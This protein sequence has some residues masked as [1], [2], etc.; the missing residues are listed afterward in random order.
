MSEEEELRQKLARK[1]QEL[2]IVQTIA[3]EINAALE[4]DQIFDVV[5]ASMDN[6]LGFRHAMILVPDKTGGWLRVAASRGYAEKGIGATVEFGKGQIGVVARRRRVM[7]MVGMGTQM[8]IVAAARRESQQAGHAIANET[9]LPGLP[10]VRSQVVIPL[11]AKDRLIGVYVVESPEHNAFDVLD[12]AFVGIV[13]SQVATAIDNASA[14]AEL[15]RQVA[16][17]SK[18]LADALSKLS[19]QP[20]PLS[21]AR[22]VDGRYR[23]IRKLGA[24]GMGTVYEVERIT[25]Q[26]RFA[27]KTLRGRTEPD[28]MARFAREAHVAAEQL[29]PNLVPVVDIGIADGALFLVMPLVDG[30]S[31]EQQRSRFGDATWARPLLGHVAI[32]LAALHERGI[33]HRDLKPANILLDRGVP[34]IADFGLAALRGVVAADTAASGELDAAVAATMQPGP[35]GLTRAGDI[36]GTP[37]YMAPEL[38]SG[39]RDIGPASDMFAFGLLAYE[40]VVGC[41]AFAEPPVLSRLGGREIAVPVVAKIEPVIA[42]CLE[43]DPASRPTSA[44][45]VGALRARPA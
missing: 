23:V 1:T 44:E 5:L 25:D 13:G 11:V 10:N 36:F 20:R 40:M 31:L 2:Q 26:H 27:L 22:E 21:P 33:V 19:S 43:L 18:E 41:T 30:G 29:H 16:E 3:T 32:G 15:Q 38:A 37:A 4:L 8:A 7:R 12:E 28:S 24:G 39:A 42:R 45:L 34:R 6:A 17:R 9:R 35:A 14:Y